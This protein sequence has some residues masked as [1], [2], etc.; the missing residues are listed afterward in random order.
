MEVIDSGSDSS[1]SSS[2][3][4]NS[5]AD[6]CAERE[7]LKA[8]HRIEAEALDDEQQLLDR[9]LFI[10]RY[11]LVAALRLIH[12]GLCLCWKLGKVHH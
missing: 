1:S 10:Q 11:F 8:A 4:G 9:Q 12:N 5:S 7:R 6:C 3:S 2:S